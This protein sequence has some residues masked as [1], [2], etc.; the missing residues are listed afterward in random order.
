MEGLWITPLMLCQAAID[1]RE[2]QTRTAAGRAMDALEA[3]GVELTAENL[4]RQ[5]EVS[6]GS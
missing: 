4:L 6:D 3:E 2:N 5:L 1:Q